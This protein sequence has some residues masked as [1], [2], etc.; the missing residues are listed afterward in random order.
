MIWEFVL[1]DLKLLIQFS[2]IAQKIVALIK[3]MMFNLE[4]AYVLTDIMDMNV[5]RNM[6]S[7]NVE[8]VFDHNI[9]YVTKW[10]VYAN[11]N[12]VLVVQTVL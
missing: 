4:H 6:K 2:L 8:H 1:E 3:D 5:R 12:Q 7:K 11:V 10:L 9:K